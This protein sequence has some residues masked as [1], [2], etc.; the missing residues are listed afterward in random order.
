VVRFMCPETIRRQGAAMIEGH[1]GEIFTLTC[2]TS[3]D[4]TQLL[5]SGGSDCTVKL[6]DLASRL[7]LAVFEGHTHA[8][9]CLAS[10][11]DRDGVQLL[12]SGSYDSTI[13][14]WMS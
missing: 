6:W 12:A 14:L 13:V 4:G 11:S 2:F 3:P 7:C 1:G 9:W 8:V 10:F 5:A